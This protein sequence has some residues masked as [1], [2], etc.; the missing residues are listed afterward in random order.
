[1]LLAARFWNRLRGPRRIGDS[2]SL[3]KLGAHKQHK[4]IDLRWCSLHP[5]TKNHKYS[6]FAHIVGHRT[7][8]SGWSCQCPGLGTTY[9]HHFLGYHVEPLLKKEV[10]GKPG[11]SKLDTVNIFGVGTCIPD[12][13]T[14]RVLNLKIVDLGRATL[15]LARGL[16]STPAPG[17]G[18]CRQQSG[19]RAAGCDL[20][21]GQIRQHA[22]WVRATFGIFA[23]LVETGCIPR[24]ILH[25][26]RW[27][28]TARTRLCTHRC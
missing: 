3:S 11:F 2:A 1:M 23:R 20:A 5:Q 19:A 9:T 7:V 14:V 8:R 27:A 4:Q 24:A 28:L 12:V 15:S 13:H 10:H 26:R 17:P 18:S 16:M 21:R 25:A 22:T 6:F